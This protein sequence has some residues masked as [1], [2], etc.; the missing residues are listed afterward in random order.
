MERNGDKIDA[1]AEVWINREG[2]L[3][4]TQDDVKGLSV[5]SPALLLRVNS[6]RFLP[7]RPKMSA[8]RIILCCL[9]PG[10]AM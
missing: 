5:S 10:A 9:P 6:R 4:R 1:R 8:Q 3:A 2:V 7:Y